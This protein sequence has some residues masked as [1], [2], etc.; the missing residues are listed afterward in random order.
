MDSAPME[1]VSYSIMSVR[2]PVAIPI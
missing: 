2:F 1:L